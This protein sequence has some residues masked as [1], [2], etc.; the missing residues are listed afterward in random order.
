MWLVDAK[1]K[2]LLSANLEM[3]ISVLRKKPNQCGVQIR[4]ILSL[5]GFGYALNFQVQ[6]Q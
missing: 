2:G 6:G 4:L 5:C 3:C 1:D